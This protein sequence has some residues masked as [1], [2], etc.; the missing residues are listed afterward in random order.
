MEFFRV[1]YQNKSMLDISNLRN[2]S[3]NIFQNLNICCNSPGYSKFQGSCP[4]LF[5]IKK[6]NIPLLHGL[7]ASFVQ[8]EIEAIFINNLPQTDVDLISRIKDVV[9]SFPEELKK[10]PQEIRQTSL[11]SDDSPKSINN[12]LFQDSQ[13]PFDDPYEE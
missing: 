5:I 3:F 9:S 7:I 11:V 1:V 8:N 12:D 13:D 6:Q 10:L 4:G 2:C